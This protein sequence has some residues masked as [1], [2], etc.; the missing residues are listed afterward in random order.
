M[1]GSAREVAA[2]LAARQSFLLT[3]HAR[4]DGDAVGSPLALALGLIGHPRR[5]RRWA[6]GTYAEGV[7]GLGPY[8]E[9]HVRT[10][11]YIGVAPSGGGVANVCLVTAT[12]E[13]LPD[14]AARL[15]RALRDDP[16]WRD[17]LAFH[18]YFNGD[19]GAG[20]GAMHQTGWTAL[21]ADLILDPPGPGVLVLG[22]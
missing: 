11:Q 7:E 10:G 5:P 18:E 12:R 21:V 8:G 19:D 1:S 6:I 14:P 16:A 3:S 9:M 13:S 20:L 22:R 17:N 4:P 2:A 15:W